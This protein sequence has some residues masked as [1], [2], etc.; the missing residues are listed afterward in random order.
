MVSVILWVQDS[1]CDSVK[2]RSVTSFQHDLAGLEDMVNTL[3]AFAQDKIPK[4]EW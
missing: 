3:V 1:K 4:S 2:G